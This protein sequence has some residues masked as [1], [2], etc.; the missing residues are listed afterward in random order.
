MG[1]FQV[2]EKVVPY[3]PNVQSESNTDCKTKLRELASNTDCKTAVASFINSRLKDNAGAPIA[4]SRADID[5]AHLLSFRQPSKAD[6]VPTI[7]VRFHARDVRDGVLRSRRQV[8]G[9]NIIITEDLTSKNAK[10]LSDLK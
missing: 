2:F 4:V 6:A 5:A 8:K 3:V 10:L 9:S 1:V 7:F